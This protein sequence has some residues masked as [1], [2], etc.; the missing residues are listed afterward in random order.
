VKKLA[1]EDFGTEVQGVRLRGDP[2]VR[3]EPETF[4]VVFPGGDV[5]VVRCEDGSY[6]VHVRVD[7]EKDV[8]EERAEVVGTVDEAH[9]DFFERYPTLAEADAVRR[10]GLVPPEVGPYHLAVRVTKAP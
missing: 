4:R 7:T 1:V 3:P 2:K 10:L 8:R 6:W 5:D 9:V